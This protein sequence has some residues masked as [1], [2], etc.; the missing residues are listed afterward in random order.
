MCLLEDFCVPLATG[1]RW[2]FEIVARNS[3]ADLSMFEGR[4]LIFRGFWCLS[5]M[6]LRG[7]TCDIFG[8]SVLS[9]AR[10]PATHNHSETSLNAPFGARCF[11][12]GVATVIAPF[13]V[14][15][16]APFGARCVTELSCHW[17]C[18]LSLFV[19]LYMALGVCS[20]WLLVN[21][22][23]NSR[24]SLSIFESRSLIFRGFWPLLAMIL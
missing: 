8:R 10:N 6:D 24:S 3:G 13:G 17:L 22:A 15:L 5:V 11:L 19:G 21:V 14:G 16:N 1:C 2:L 9:D 18:R 7:I 4:S 20:G 12:T 23:R